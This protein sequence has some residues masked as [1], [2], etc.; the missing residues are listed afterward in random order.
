MALKNIIRNAVQA[1]AGSGKLR[2]AIH[3]ADGAVEL[4][5][6]DSRP[7]IPPQNRDKVF[8]PLFSTKTHGIGFGLS[9]TKM[10]IENHGGGIRAENKPG[11]GAVFIITLPSAEK[12]S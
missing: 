12:P 10:I 6:A 5:I 7:G 3:R 2:I 11:S 9:I 1:M 8:D 4:R